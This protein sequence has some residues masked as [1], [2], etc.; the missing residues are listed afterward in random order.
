MPDFIIAFFQKSCAGKRRSLDYRSSSQSWF[1]V[2]L[3]SLSI[4]DGI[5]RACRGK[6]SEMVVSRG[7]MNFLKNDSLRQ[8]KLNAA[9]FYY[10]IFFKNHA[11]A[12]GDLLSP[13][14]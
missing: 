14:K 9:G 7:S 11:P 3:V 1:S 5:L 12:V 13:E 2:D 8:Q 10:R 4:I 6:K